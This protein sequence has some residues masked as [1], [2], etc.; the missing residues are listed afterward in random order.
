MGGSQ[1]RSIART[2]SDSTAGGNGG[3]GDLDCCQRCFLFEPPK[4][5]GSN[6]NDAMGSPM[7]DTPVQRRQLRDAAYKQVLNQ[8]DDA[9]NGSRN[10]SSG[11]YASI[12]YAGLEKEV[13]SASSRLNGERRNHDENDYPQPEVHEGK[14]RLKE[15]A[16]GLGDI[17]LY[18]KSF[19]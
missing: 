16:F 18:E 1:S 8:D 15:N 3:G 9:V 12:R 2:E 17:R 11:R 13:S 4:V 10:G 5:F 14:V 19:R 6:G 7:P